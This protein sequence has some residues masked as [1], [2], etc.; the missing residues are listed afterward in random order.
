M[1]MYQE[2]TPCAKTLSVVI[3]DNLEHVF[4]IA[5]WMIVLRRGQCIGTRIK[6][7]TT[8]EDIVGL[9]TGA[10]PADAYSESSCE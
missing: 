8:N 9:T 5:D 7:H 4:E 10:I 1:R 6:R 3:T 2:S